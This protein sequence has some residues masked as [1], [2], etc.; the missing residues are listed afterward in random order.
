MTK[1]LDKLENISFLKA[2]ADFVDSYKWKQVIKNCKTIK[3]NV[4]WQGI[5]SIEGEYREQ[6]KS[7]HFVGVLEAQ[8]NLPQ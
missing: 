5:M 3:V 2:K 1:L 4:D 8:V 7:A 6:P